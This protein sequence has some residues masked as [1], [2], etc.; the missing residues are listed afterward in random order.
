M[1]RI[2]FDPMRCNLAQ[3]FP[4]VGEQGDMPGALD[5][6]R[7]LTLVL[8]ARAGLAARPDLSVL[9]NIAPQDFSLLVIDVCVLICAELALAWVREETARAASLAFILKILV[10][11]SLTPYCERSMIAIKDHDP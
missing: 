5:G 7:Q 10:T 1:P 4:R 9:R 11:H 6:A 2:R 8:G 3:D